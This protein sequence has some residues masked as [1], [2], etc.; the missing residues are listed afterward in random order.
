MSGPRVPKAAALTLLVLV[1]APLCLAAYK[2]ALLDYRLA[3]VLP[4]TERRV[5]VR[6]S[7]DGNFGQVSA[8]TFGPVDYAIL[9]A[10]LLPLVWIPP[11]WRRL[12]APRLAAW[13]RTR[14]SPAERALLG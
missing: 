9:L 2:I 10:Y 1:V 5:N 3:E 4:Q 8:R 11:L 7:L 6:M 13:D 14:A 12:I